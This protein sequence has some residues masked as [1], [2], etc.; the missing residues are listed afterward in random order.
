MSAPQKRRWELPIFAL[1]HGP[2]GALS[3]PPAVFLPPYFAEHLGLPLALIPVI[4][5]GARLLDIIIDPMIGGWQDRTRTKFGRRRLWLTLSTP[6]VML[7]AWV[8]FIGLPRGVDPLI[9]GAAMFA[10]YV[11]YATI[12]IAHLGWAGE[13]RQ[14][15]GGRTNAFGAVQLAG[16]TG[17]MLIL[18]LPSFVRQAGWGDDADAVHVMGWSI[19]ITLPLCTALCIALVREPDVPP[20]PTL[21]WRVQWE[22]LRTNASLRQVLA[23]DLL[24][25]IAQGVSGGLFLFYFQHILGF[26][27]ESQTLLFVYFVSGVLGVPLWMMLGRRIGKHR[28]LQAACLYAT[29]VTLLLFILPRGSFWIAL[30]AMF[31]A[32]LHQ[33]ANNLL[34]RAMLAD[35]LDEDMVK[36]GAQRSGLFYGLMLTTSKLGLAMGPL[37]YGVLAMFGFDPQLGGAN[38]SEAMAALAALFIGVPAAIYLLSAWSLRFYTLDETRQRALRAEIDARS[39]QAASSQ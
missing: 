27:R 32:G 31:V 14:D 8:V 24:L 33:G 6:I 29:V 26:E 38:S 1:P 12:M 9:A 19:I 36:T 3:L 16:M 21:S 4:F 11:S 10:L 17:A 13:L 7:F 2:I 34:L 39:A 18:L 15:Y 20:E 22:A 23:P 35:V 30:A 5:V 37:T 28:A 25:G